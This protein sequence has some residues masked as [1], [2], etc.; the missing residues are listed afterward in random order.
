MHA[1][2]S[3]AGSWF[4]RFPT[5]AWPV[6]TIGGS[7]IVTFL[8]LG[9]LD[10]KASKLAEDVARWTIRNLRDE[11]GFFYYQKRRFYTVRKPYMRWSQAWMLYALAR[12]LES[13]E[14]ATG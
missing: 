10:S 2:N 7:S 13:R 9:D 14:D 12:L 1:P 3:S 4:A 6:L 5:T 8:E 11:Q